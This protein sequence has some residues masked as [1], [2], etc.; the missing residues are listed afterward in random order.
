MKTKIR[1]IRK[2]RL[3]HSVYLKTRLWLLSHF[4]HKALMAMRVTL[5]VLGTIV[6]M[7][8]VYT[9][10]RT[11]I[12]F[13][14][15]ILD[16]P[17][18]FNGT[19]M[20]V[21]KVPDWTHWM[22]G[23]ADMSVHYDQIPKNMLIDLPAYDLAKMQ[24]PTDKLVW[25]DES[26]TLIRNTKITYPVV[27]LGDYEFDHKENV[28]S[29]LAIDIKMPIG[30]PV[31][32]VA[33]GK[34]VKVSNINSGFGH[35]I[36]I[37]HPNVPDPENPGQ[38]TTLYSC[39]DHMD[40]LDVSE[41]QNM[42]KGQVIGTS[43]NTGTST[44]PHLHFQIDRDSA[45]WHP[46]WPFT[47]AQSAKAGLSFF[48]SVNAGLGLGD[49]QDKTVN[50]M[51]FVTQNIGSFS[52]ASSNETSVPENGA[53]TAQPT[54]E[55]VTPEPVVAPVVVTPEPTP[56][57]E[58]VEAP[59]LAQNES[60]LFQYKITGE[61]V[62]L[63]GNA[64]GLVVTDEKKQVSK[65]K[66]DDQIRASIDGTGTLLKK[67]F[68]KA[69]FVNSTLKLYVKSDVAGTANVM[70]GKS[71]YQVKFVETVSPVS[72]FKIEHDG[73]FQRNMVETIKI[74]A[75]DDSGSLAPAVNFSGAV[76]IT[77]TQGEADITPNAIT[78]ADFKGGIAK[79]KIVSSGDSPLVFRAQNG[80]LV[81]VSEP[82]RPESTLVFTDIKPGHPNY[83]A[84]KYLKDQGIVSGYKDGT[85]KP[86]QTVNRAEA[87]KMLM[88][89]F[90]VNGNSNANPNFKDVDKSA[91]FFRPLASAVEKSIVAGYKDGTFKPAN[92][93]NRAE[94]L[95]ILLK[96]TGVE[97]T[98][99]ISKPYKDVS[100]SDWFAPYAYL[101]NKMNL[102][103]PADTFRPSDGMTRAGVAETIYRM[104][105]IQSHDWVTYSKL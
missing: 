14:A 25:G 11:G 45:P 18:P 23:K 38:R 96:A 42:L 34:V 64:V 77:A 26:Q 55:P 40:R 30:T 95:K 99:E 32:A 94:Y 50:P 47:S 72:S 105:M 86:N 29:H 98:K 43:G 2:H 7:V 8:L 60:D 48:D 62:S 82:M 67:V 88:T 87:L 13:K 20:P 68:T 51:S 49:A 85:F 71:A 89:A 65:L 97:P 76:E 73:A 78:K 90:E 92:T 33:N 28:G 75:L 54:P 46:Y 31:H 12:W 74:I 81:G 27:Y 63:L 37:E 6:L 100:L 35:H 91:W 79:I 58:V 66:D 5:T 9:G 41:G 16:T 69:D 101:A 4:S 39:Y 103:Q 70:I 3:N 102:L 15:S 93:V 83:E 17:Q 24:F 53:N 36:V 1:K 104:K 19:V 59:V 21:A 10:E 44:T 22:D 84:I 56:A 80:A 57:V 52:V 61:T